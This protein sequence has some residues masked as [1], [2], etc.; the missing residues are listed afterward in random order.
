MNVN[1]NLG[2][3]SQPKPQSDQPA[4][5]FESKTPDEIRQMTE[6]LRVE[7][8]SLS[9]Q[10]DA[11]E[12]AL[13]EQREQLKTKIPNITE[14][15]EIANRRAEQLERRRRFEKKILSIYNRFPSILN[16]DQPQIISTDISILNRQL[17]LIEKRNAEAKAKI[18][19]HEKKK[20]RLQQV[21]VDLRRQN[22]LQDDLMNQRKQDKDNLSH[23]LRQELDAAKT[24]Y[25]SDGR[26]IERK[27]TNAQSLSADLQAQ[28]TSLKAQFDLLTKQ[29]S[30]A[31]QSAPTQN[32]QISQ[33]LAFRQNDLIR[34]IE[35]FSLW[36]TGRRTLRH[37]ND[38]ID[39]LNSVGQKTQESFDQSYKSIEF[40]KHQNASRIE[41]LKSLQNMNSQLSNSIKEKQVKRKDLE[42]K[43]SNLLKSFKPLPKDID[44]QLKT[45]R[46][47]QN[48]LENRAKSLDIELQVLG[49]NSGPSAADKRY[50]E[51][52]RHY[53]SQI[54]EAAS[55]RKNIDELKKKAADQETAQQSHFVQPLTS[56]QDGRLLLS[57]EAPYTVVAASLDLLEKLV[58]HPGNT[59]ENYYTG[60]LVFIHTQKNFDMTFFIQSLVSFF[61]TTEFV[62]EREERLKGLIEIWRKWFPND[63]T[64]ASSRATLSPLINLAGTSGIYDGLQHMKINIIY[65]IN[66]P[67]N[68]KETRIP[69][70][71]SPLVIAEHFTFIEL[72]IL[73][74]IPAYE[75]IGCGW[76]STDKWNKA[77]HIMKFMEHFNFISQWIVYSIIKTD[78]VDERILLIEQWIQIM[79]AA[80]EVVNYQFV[81]EIYG[82]LCNPAITHLAST[83]AGI[84]PEI[85]AIYKKYSLLTTPSGRFANYRE[86]LEALPPEVVVPYIG[87]FLTSLVYISDGNTSTK[88]LPGVPDPVINFQKFRSYAAVLNDIMVPWGK[89]MVFYLHED[90]LKRIQNI[91]PVDLSESE[92][93]QLSQKLKS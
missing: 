29:R 33:K 24:L 54:Q 45:L 40:I 1:L 67:F 49:V 21:I 48:T 81:F 51:T 74:E 5:D 50:E 90:L 87:P 86:K 76:T 27:T 60:L 62:S 57:D 75:F 37:L 46:E 71:A 53:R 93:F 32:A 26:T 84:N 10:Q 85:M 19:D 23:N 80:A 28:L 16:A 91:P 83:W 30:S 59:D 25:L 63:F 55:L 41:E 2:V 4:I 8:N 18:A 65:N 64:E 58:F 11:N 7:A 43:K 9:D 92:L 31:M 52:R 47:Q 3:G 69:F 78:S 89:D 15:Q 17:E 61:N 39:F 6:A 14:I 82:A 36:W 22:R 88:S 66:V 68:A 34:S 42:E 56:I 13:R 20:E 77:P 79:D 73:R 72:S 70:S 38:R 12:K 44:Q 35:Q